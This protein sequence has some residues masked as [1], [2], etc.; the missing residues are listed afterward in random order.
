MLRSCPQQMISP[1]FSLGL[2]ELSAT[3]SNLAFQSVKNA[4]MYFAPLVGAFKGI[5]DELRR[6]DR[7]IE[8]ARH[9]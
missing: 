4:A 2:L 6:V 3:S 5:R 9:G 8:A 7:E 1:R